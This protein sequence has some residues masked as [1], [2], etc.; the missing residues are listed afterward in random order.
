MPIYNKLVRDK[1][2][3]IIRS[4]GKDCNCITLEY[5]F[6]ISELKRKLREEVEEYTQ[7]ADD[8]EAVEELADILEVVHA[9][10]Q[11][12]KILPEDLEKVRAK[13]V[14]ERGGFKDRNFLIEVTE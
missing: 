6:Y 11:I 4:S 7:A 13:K 3:N 8:S 9:L 12:H 14:E 5:E 10:A 1:I 2:P